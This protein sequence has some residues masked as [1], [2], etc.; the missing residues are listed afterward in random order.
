MTEHVL[1]TRD[2]TKRYGA[3]VAVDHANIAIPKGAIYGLVGRNGAGKTTLMRL[4][5]GQSC[6]TG[7]ELELFGASG[8]A[9]RPQRA[10]TGAMIEIPSF[11]PFLSARA[12]LEDE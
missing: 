4:A 8:K 11:S 3:A 2:L 12:R 5:T 7:G 9:M 6:P 1:V 10:R